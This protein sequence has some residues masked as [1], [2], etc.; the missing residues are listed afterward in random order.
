M[1][2]EVKHYDNLQRKMMRV[3]NHIK[4]LALFADESSQK[5]IF[6]NEAKSSSLKGMYKT[7]RVA[8]NNFEEYMPKFY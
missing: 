8:N 2:S 6:I 7:G 5:Y 4:H 3:P 1:I